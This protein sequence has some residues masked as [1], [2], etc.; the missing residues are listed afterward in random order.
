MNSKLSLSAALLL[1]AAS[2][3]LAV[4][5]P[6]DTAIHKSSPLFINWAVGYHAYTT[7]ANVDEL[8]QT[9]EK[10]LGVPGADVYEIVCLGDGGSII[11]HFP[12]P[13]CDGPGPDFAVFE[14]AMSD[15]FLEL[16]FVEV[17]SDGE[18]FHRFPCESLTPGPVGA[19]GM[20]Y[21]EEIDGLAGKYPLGYGTPFDLADLPDSPTLDKRNIRFI[22]IVDIIGDGR[23]LDSKGRK[24]Y[25][26][27]PTTGSAGFDLAGV[28]V[29][30]QNDGP[31]AV[32]EARLT[33]AGFVLAWESNPGSLYEIRTSTDLTTWTTLENAVPEPAAAHTRRI[34]PA[35][36]PRRFYQVVR[37]KKGRRPGVSGE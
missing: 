31:F 26:P 24:I 3:S 5:F 4:G 21:P 35:G 2:S 1:S 11:M 23:E 10:A 37:R 25:D 13:V 15:T 20:V 18:N 12:H 17:S 16:A 19:F 6:T 33:A 14:N 32:T 34:L 9:P 29:I 8:W 22:R 7:G 36:G 27:H 28:G 30:H